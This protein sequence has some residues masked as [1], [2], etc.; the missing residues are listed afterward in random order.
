MLR[1][2]LQDVER[3]MSFKDYLDKVANQ[4]KK[5]G[6]PAK[7]IVAKGKADKAI[8]DYAT[9]NKVD[10]I[11]MST[12]GRSGISRWAAGSI[13]DRVAR[14]SAIPVLLISPANCK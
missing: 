9:K 2:L 1:Q 14:Y 7:G 5:E 12:H 8:L 3:R 13:A 4:L 11:I 10:L 6:L